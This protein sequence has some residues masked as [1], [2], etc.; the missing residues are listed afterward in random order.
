MFRAVVAAMSAF[1][2]PYM[3]LGSKRVGGVDQALGLLTGF[4]GAAGFASWG[5]LTSRH[6]CRPAN[7]A[8]ELDLESTG[9]RSFGDATGL[10]FTLDL[11]GRFKS[12][13]A[14]AEQVFGYTH[15]ELSRSKRFRSFLLPEEEAPW[16][17]TVRALLGGVPSAAYLARIRTFS[18]NEIRLQLCCRI[19]YS[20]GLPQVEAVGRVSHADNH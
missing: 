2:P 7:I 1:S 12:A 5:F 16:L 18:G 15:H 8:R 20:S 3:G 6:P 4:A 19:E 11:Q 14:C 13:N 9:H 17:E 10:V